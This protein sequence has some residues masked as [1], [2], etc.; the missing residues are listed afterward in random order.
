MC[1]SWDSSFCPTLLSRHTGS[2]KTRDSL[3]TPVCSRIEFLMRMIV[4][5]PPWTASS[6]RVETKGGGSS[7][8]CRTSISQPVLSTLSSLRKTT[9]ASQKFSSMLTPV[10]QCRQD[11]RL[12]HHHHSGHDLPAIHLCRCRWYLLRLELWPSPR[13]HLAHYRWTWL[14]H[15]WICPGC[16]D[17][18]HTSSLRR[19]LHLPHGCLRRQLCHYRMGCIYTF[20]DKGEESRR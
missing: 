6:R 8:S 10:E 7:V 20:P 15:R 9:T 12:Q 13:T 3:P 11:S 4:K 19:L 5:L 2:L 17:I 16:L 14:R 18:E 1:P